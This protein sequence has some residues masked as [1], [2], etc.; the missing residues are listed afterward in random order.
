MLMR[1]AATLGCCITLTANASAQEVDVVARLR[2]TQEVPRVSVQMTG[3]LSDTRFLNAMRSGFPLY[4]EYEIELR[5]ERSNWFD[6]V[7]DQY[8]LEYVVLYDP[9][10]ESFVFDDANTREEISSEIALRRKLES[11]YEFGLRPNDEGRFYYAVTVNARTL[12]DEDVD[13]VFDWLKGDN[14]TTAVR[15]RSLLSRTARRL[16]VRVAPLPRI[17]V[18]AKTETF[19]WPTRDP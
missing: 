7:V 8:Y 18:S 5:S 1:V 16:L 14:D 13:E 15:H 4:I 19:R 10:R 11:V 17:S 2:P 12:S 9:V 3:L 6:P